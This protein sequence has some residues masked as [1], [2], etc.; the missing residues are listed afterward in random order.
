[1]SK[2]LALATELFDLSLVDLEKL[3]ANAVKSSFAP[4]QDRVDLIHQRILPSFA[5]LFAELNAQAFS[6]LN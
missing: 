2:E 3:T 4:Y 6:S 5:I 1:M